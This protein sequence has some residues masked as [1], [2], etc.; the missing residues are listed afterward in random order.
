MEQLTVNLGHRTYSISIGSGLRAAVAAEVFS[1][2]KAGRKIAVLTDQTIADRQ[3]VALQGMFAHTPKL[4][5]PAGEESKSLSELG[6]VLDFLAAQSLDRS[7]VLWVVG[8]GVMGDL[9]GFAAA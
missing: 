8:G 7:G 5:L 9:G 6:H 2:M 1:Q 4:I 3:K